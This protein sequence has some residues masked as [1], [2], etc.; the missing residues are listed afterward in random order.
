MR[1]ANL[2]LV[3]DTASD[4]RLVKEAV[5]EIGVPVEVA[6]AKDGI[7]AMNYL[8]DA[9]AG[10]VSRPDLVLLDL[11]LPR[12]N[13]R[14]VL[15]EIK[16]SPNLR[17][18]PVVVMTSSQAEEDVNAAYA[19]NA[20]CYIIKPSDLS[21]YVDVVRSIEDFWFLTAR[22]PENSGSNSREESRQTSS[23]I[24][25]RSRG[26]GSRRTRIAIA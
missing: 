8:R 14:E 3:E 23:T 20:N 21:E 26:C 1:V 16:G 4:V 9:E 12:K 10:N 18:I 6:V 25:A 5:K 24:N 2:L 17:Q 13:G 7:E 11:N 19:L 15:T 22:L